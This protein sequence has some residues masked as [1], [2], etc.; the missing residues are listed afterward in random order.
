MAARVEIQKKKTF[1]FLR[2]PHCDAGDNVFCL[3]VNLFYP[4]ARINMYNMHHLY[5]VG[6]AYLICVFNEHC[7]HTV[8]RQHGMV[9]EKLTSLCVRACGRCR[10]AKKYNCLVRIGSAAELLEANRCQ[11]SKWKTIKLKYCSV[12]LALIWVSS[13][14]IVFI[15]LFACSVMFHLGDDGI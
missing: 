11:I 4:Y 5:A 6:Y 8:H 7:S 12:G 13:T 14:V 10:Q 9:K 2:P 15:F 1:P 3:F